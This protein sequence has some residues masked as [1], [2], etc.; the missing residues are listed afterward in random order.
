M[1]LRLVAL[2]CWSRV[3]S[4]DTSLGSTHE[5]AGH[6]SFMRGIK[7]NVEVNANDSQV[8]GNIDNTAVGGLGSVD[9]VKM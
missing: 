1:I 4:G 3:A 9:G 7:D 5:V 2:D 8:K 6:N